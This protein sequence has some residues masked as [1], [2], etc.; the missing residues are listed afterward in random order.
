[1]TDKDNHYRF[2]RDHYKHE[3]FEGRNSP[4]WGA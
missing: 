2:L 1:M 3:R 4:V